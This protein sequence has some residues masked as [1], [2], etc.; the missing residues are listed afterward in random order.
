MHVTVRGR[1][2][3]L[4]QGKR[5]KRESSGEEAEWHADASQSNSNRTTDRPR[6][7]ASWAVEMISI[8]QDANA[9]L[10]CFNQACGVS[11]GRV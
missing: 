11:V 9:T 4:A 5:D 6:V 10:R 7:P 8:S 3:L 1:A 2:P